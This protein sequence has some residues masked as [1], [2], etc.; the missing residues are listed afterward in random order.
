M[1]L[2]KD[3][4]VNTGMNLKPKSNATKT[5]FAITL[6]SAQSLMMSANVL[7][8]DTSQEAISGSDNTATYWGIGIGTTLGAILGGPVGAAAGAALGGSV[9]YGQD[10]DAALEQTEQELDSQVTSLSEMEGELKKSNMQLEVLRAQTR[11][12]ERERAMHAAELADLKAKKLSEREQEE[13]LAGVAKHYSQEVYY[14]HNSSSIPDYAK[15]RIDELA[16]FMQEHPSIVIS[17]AGHSDL[18]G[19]ED[20]NL[21]LTQARVDAIRDY[22]IDQGIDAQRIEAKAYGEAF[23]TVT[24]GDASNYVLDRRVA[25]EL[26]VRAQESLSDQNGIADQDGSADQESLQAQQARDD[27][28]DAPLLPLAI[29]V[30][31]R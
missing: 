15:S 4:S 31:G 14:R 6:L 8:Q 28:A 2:N 16:A 18:V 17:L 3:F 26:G 23:A 1:R 13:I 27:D 30:G 29:N 10:K 19:A 9:G 7:A 25:I 22:L 5:A 12:L 24:A 20:A 11:K 21:A